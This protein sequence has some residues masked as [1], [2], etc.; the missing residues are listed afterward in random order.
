MKFL[1]IYWIPKILVNLI[2]LML[3]DSNG[4]V[5]I[6]GQ[7]TEAFGIKRDLRQGYALYT[8]LFNIVLEKVKRNVK[9]T[10]NGTIFNRTRQYTVYP[11][12][13]LIFGRLV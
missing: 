8:A 10:P 9:T 5:K 13:V 7:M 4:K 6:L 11:D 3:Q 1:K 12:K 2:K